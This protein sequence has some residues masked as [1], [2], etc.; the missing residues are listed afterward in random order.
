MLANREPWLRSPLGI[1]TGAKGGGEALPLRP[2][3]DFDKTSKFNPQT[4]WFTEEPSSREA[5]LHIEDGRH[6]ETGCQKNL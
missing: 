1:I 4:C 6:Y 5:A 2:V 3:T